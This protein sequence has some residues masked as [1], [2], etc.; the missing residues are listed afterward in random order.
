MSNGKY[1]E[2]QVNT[3][4]L[5]EYAMQLDSIS[6]RLQLLQLRLED[7]SS[8]SG[9]PM[10]ELQAMDQGREKI[11]QCIGYLRETAADFDTVERSITSRM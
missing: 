8:V 2:V 11:G 9:I 5:R 4:D 10:P 3:S 1:G 7:L 6:R